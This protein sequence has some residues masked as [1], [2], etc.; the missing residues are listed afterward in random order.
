MSERVRTQEA[1]REQDVGTTVSFFL[2]TYSHKQTRGN[3]LSENCS[4]AK[5]TQEGLH[6]R[7]K[8][9]KQIGN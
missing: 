3:V 1:L 7:Q 6:Q 8:A 2:T 4:V 5:M 9:R